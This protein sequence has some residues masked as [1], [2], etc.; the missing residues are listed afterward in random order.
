M[1]AAGTEMSAVIPVAVMGLM[2]MMTVSVVVTVIT[3]LEDIYGAIGRGG[4]D[5]G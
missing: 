1:L 4:V 2:M 3:L 5:G